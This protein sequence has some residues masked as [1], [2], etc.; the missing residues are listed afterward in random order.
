MNRLHLHIS[1]ENLDQSLA[2][3]RTLFGAEPS[4]LKPDYAK[5]LLDDP[6]VNFVI[7]TQSAANPGL[8]HVGIQSETPEELAE[9]TER[10]HAAEAATFV[11]EATTCC[12]A[13]SDKTWVEDPS[14][15]HWENF[16]TFG[17]A[18]TYY[19]AHA[20]QGVDQKP[21]TSETQASCCG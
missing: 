2:F 6:R 11:E 1:V 20:K 14:G 18:E 17:E 12:Y 9:I 19:G 16:Y 13:Q 7:S 15:I 4:V 8:S 21:E 10:L 5:W 3:Y